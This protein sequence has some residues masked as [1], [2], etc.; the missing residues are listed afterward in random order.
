MSPPDILV[1]AWYVVHTKS[2]FENV[3]FEGLSKKSLDTFLPKIRVQS[4][5]RDRRVM[6]DAPLFPGYIFVRTDLNPVEHLEIVKTVGAVKLIGNASGPVPV[7]DS[8]IASLK[9][10]VDTENPITTGSG[11][12]KGDRVMVI[13]GPLAGVTGTF[14]HYRGQDRVIVE[15]VALG[16]FAAVEVDLADVEKLPPIAS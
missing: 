13:N 5:R 7:S 4:K 1:P 3:V 8:A 15:V 6:L 12:Q 9:I 11:F 14:S 16:Q 2:R 10:M